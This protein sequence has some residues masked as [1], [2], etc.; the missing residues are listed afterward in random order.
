MKMIFFQ[1]P[2][3]YLIKSLSHEH[4]YIWANKILKGLISCLVHCNGLCYREKI[5]MPLTS[6]NSIPSVHPAIAL[7][8]DEYRCYCCRGRLRKGSARANRS[9]VARLKSNQVRRY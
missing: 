1:V 4:E 9:N 5:S 2:F 8:T 7:N 3:I 6:L